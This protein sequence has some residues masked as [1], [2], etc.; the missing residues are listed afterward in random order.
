[1]DFAYLRQFAN[2]SWTRGAPNNFTIIHYKYERQVDGNWEE[3]PIALPE[4]E[5]LTVKVKDSAQA[6]TETNVIEDSNWGKPALLTY[7]APF[8]DKVRGRHIFIRPVVLTESEEKAYQTNYTLTNYNKGWVTNQ[9]KMNRDYRWDKNDRY[10]SLKGQTNFYGETPVMAAA[11]HVPEIYPVPMVDTNGLK[12]NIVTGTTSLWGKLNVTET[13]LN[14]FYLKYDAPNNG[15]WKA[16]QKPGSEIKTL[17]S[18][19]AFGIGMTKS[20]KG[21]DGSTAAAIS[22]FKQGVVSKNKFVLNDTY[23]ENF[24]GFY[25]LIS[26]P[27]GVRS[28]GAEDERVLHG[29]FVPYRDGA[30]FKLEMEGGLE[31]PTSIKLID[32]YDPTKS[33]TITKENMP[34]NWMTTAP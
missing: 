16:I 4:P 25:A 12:M 13:A 19:M 2:S 28:L 20:W 29:D 15:V 8:Q 30:F 24:V 5:V 3:Y 9:A 1:M 7:G 27:K 17:F 31:N 11:V 23:P 32:M 33:Y 34:D 18:I 26:D 6:V 14:K 10:M 22:P 21:T